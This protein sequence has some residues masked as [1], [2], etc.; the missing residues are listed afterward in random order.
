MEKYTEHYTGL[1]G[2]TVDLK[3]STGCNYVHMSH[4]MFKK[5]RNK[6]YF[7]CTQSRD[8]CWGCFCWKVCNCHVTL[9][10][11]IPFVGEG[12]WLWALNSGEEMKRRE[13]IGTFRLKQVKQILVAYPQ[14][15]NTETYSVLVSKVHSWIKEVPRYSS[16]SC[17]RTLKNGFLYKSV[18]GSH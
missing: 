2:V 5:G 10:T 18:R 3:S 1:L 13:T 4:H 12:R 7:L 11:N 6:S 15:Q 16:R 14:P 17:W 8:D 9:T